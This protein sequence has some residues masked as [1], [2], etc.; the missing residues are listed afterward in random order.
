MPDNEVKVTFTGEDQLSAVTTK[1]N[2]SFDQVSQS[3]DKA[4]ASSKKASFS[5]TELKSGLDLASRGLQ[6][7]QKGYDETVG[8]TMKYAQSVRDLAMV[9]GTG[10][11]ETS[12]LLQVLDDFQLGAEDVT[13]AVR[14]M[15]SQGLAPTMDTLAKLSDKYLSINDAQ[16]RNKFILDN[17]GKSGLQWVNVL[18]QGGDKLRAMSDEVSGNLI[19]TDKQVAATE[20][21]RLALDN[22]NDTLE[23]TK[24]SIGNQLIPDLTQGIWQLTHAKDIISEMIKLRKAGAGG[25]FVNPRELTEIQLQAEANIKNSEAMGEYYRNTVQ[26]ASAS[27]DAGA[28]FES[29]ADKAKRLADEAKAAEEAIKAV[30]ETNKNFASTVENVAGATREYNAG[31]AE[32]KAQL[33]AHKITTEEYTQK[34]DAL[35]AKYDE[36]TNAIVADLVMMKLTA[37]GTFDTADLDTYLR[38]LE[39]LGIVSADDVQATKDLYNE[40]L[41]LTEP[42][43]NVS[44]NLYH[45]GKRGEDAANGMN[46][47]GDAASGTSDKLNTTVNPALAE[48]KGLIDG[49]QSKAINVDVYVKMHGGTPGTTGW[50]GTMFTTGS[51]AGLHP[52]GGGQ[53]TGGDLRP[54]W[55]LIGDMP[56]GQLGPYTEAV[57]NEGGRVHV[58][59]AQETRKLYGAGSLTGAQSMY[60]A[61]E[62]PGTFTPGGYGMYGY[63]PKKKSGGGSRPAPV[64][65]HGSG[66]GGASEVVIP[67]FPGV[68]GEGA[69]AANTGSAATVAATVAQTREQNKTN[70]LL[71]QLIATVATNSGVGQAIQGV[72]SKFS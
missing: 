33:D 14:K 70:Q 63:T 64:S 53:W 39:K 5:F 11:E 41:G 40:A 15:T 17:L 24:I 18:Q 20:K 7:L 66:G 10:A 60:Y 8:V 44:D 29:E 50:Q 59:N 35:K 68:S 49:L 65:V 46:T 62:G 58:Y 69:M 71:E 45:T 47:F 21:Y 43:K 67:A 34:V 38:A 42:L 52:G 56:G 3:V 31:L 28:A 12:R 23:G 61:S 36:A 37:D 51:Q 27:E 48:T 72:N 32:A 26:A 16:E 19:L 25:T 30:S 6:L 13:T 9:S 57:Y 55:T 1:V 54:G 2:K 22:L 4:A